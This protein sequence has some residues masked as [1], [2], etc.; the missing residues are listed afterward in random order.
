[1]A[2]PGQP[3]LRSAKQDG[4]TDEVEF[5]RSETY[6]I[7]ITDTQP[8]FSVRLGRLSKEREAL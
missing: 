3:D 6:L 7:A 5:H 1:M 2:T 8:F 4:E